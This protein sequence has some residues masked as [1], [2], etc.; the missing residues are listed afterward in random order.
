MFSIGLQEKYNHL[1]VLLQMAKAD[2]FVNIAELT[3]I[4][5]VSQKLGI[6]KEKLDELANE[7]GNFSAPF[8]KEERN[9]LLYEVT[10][11]M[12]VDGEVLETEIQLLKE[13]SN[14]LSIASNK[15]TSLLGY[16]KENSSDLMDKKVFED[17]LN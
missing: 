17:L 2:G 13:L 8:S 3:Y 12:Y 9:N 15:Q 10:K 5:W 4:V 1:R 14:K 7:E 6:D 11:M 16:V